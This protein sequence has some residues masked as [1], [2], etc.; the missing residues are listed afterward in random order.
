M[1]EKYHQQKS[2]A[3]TI[4]RNKRSSVKNSTTMTD[5]D[6]TEFEITKSR[7]RCQKL[8]KRPIARSKTVCDY[9]EELY[10]K[11]GSIREDALGKL[12][13]EFKKAV[14]YEFAQNICVTLTHRCEN[15]LKRGSALEI[16]LALQLI[17]LLAITL[18]AGDHAH[19]IYEYSL[20]FLPQVLKSKSSHSAKALECLAIVTLIGAKNTDETERSM[21]IIWKIMNEDTKPNVVAAAIS[22]WSLLLSEING[23]CVNHKKWKG[24][25]SYLLKQLEEDYDQNV[26]SA[27]VEALG[28]IFENGSL[29]KFSDDAENYANLKD[30]KDDILIRASSVTKENALKL[31][32]G[33]SDKKITLTICET[34]LT[35][36]SFSLVK[37]IN[38]IKRYLGDGFINHMK[39][40]EHLHNIF[41]FWPETTYRDDEDLYEPEFEKVALRVF[42]P[43]IRREAC[44]KRISMSPSS[45]LSKANTQ[46]RNKYRMLA[47]KTKA[48][49]YGVDQ[50]FEYD[51][52]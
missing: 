37:Q 10:K 38:Y 28:V 9:L 14:R 30:M 4:V 33:N 23:W 40:N 45:F 41:Q 32:E 15:S 8:I 21:E 17:G 18:G 47:E 16:D 5:S 3:H 42:T 39:D 43:H 52:Y 36:R 49:E 19:E 2:K 25:F 35:L 27:C 31:L 22:A 11:K 1:Q 7:K 50:E 51:E 6:C 20:E 44:I 48:G 29:E 12:I 46:L 13:I 34:E 26:N 24:L